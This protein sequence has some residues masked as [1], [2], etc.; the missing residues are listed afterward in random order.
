MFVHSVLVEEKCG[1][2][3]RL[4][5]E[6]RSKCRKPFEDAES[7]TRLQDEE[8][9]SLLQE[10]ANNHSGPRDALPSSRGCP[11]SNLRQNET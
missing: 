6:V 8:S 10:K 1:T 3:E 9:D 11:K 7:G 5:Q 4:V 2:D